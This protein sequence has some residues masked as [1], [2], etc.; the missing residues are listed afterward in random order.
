MLTITCFES[1]IQ[2][3]APRHENQPLAIHVVFARTAVF[4][5]LTAQPWPNQDAF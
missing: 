3:C 1:V 5:A 2:T 4:I